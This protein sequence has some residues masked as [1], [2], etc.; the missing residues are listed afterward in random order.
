MITRKHLLL[1]FSLVLA[2]LSTGSAFALEAVVAAAP[3]TQAPQK[4]EELPV[5]TEL[6]QVILE[7]QELDD[8]AGL[9]LLQE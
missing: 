5:L 8:A 6:D 2:T 7:S 9:A 1:S 3:P 4:K